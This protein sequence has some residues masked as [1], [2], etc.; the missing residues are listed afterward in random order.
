MQKVCFKRN[1]HLYERV[2]ILEW[3][4]IG[5]KILAKVFQNNVESSDLLAIHDL[6][7]QD[8]DEEKVNRW[9]VNV[10]GVKREWSN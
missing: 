1:W 7:D 8:D 9:K 5:N 10:W 2:Y 6:D 4:L 3:K